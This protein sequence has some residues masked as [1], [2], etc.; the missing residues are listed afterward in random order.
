MRKRV[1][2]IRA[3]PGRRP[4]AHPDARRVAELFGLERDGPAGDA[5]M[6]DGLRLSLSAGEVVAVVGPSGA[7]KSVLLD[8]VARR[9]PDAARLDPA[10]LASCKLPAVAAV[11]AGELSLPERL[12]LL[13]RCGLAEARALV[14]P[15]RRLSGGQRHRL[16]YA[17]ALAAAGRTPRPLVIADEFAATLDPATAWA[18]ARQ[19]GKLARARRTAL[20]LATPRDE[21]LAAMRPDRLVVKPLG[22]P[23]RILERPDLPPVEPPGWRIERVRLRDYAPL[24]RFHYLAGPPAAH[25]RIWGVR[26]EARGPCAGPGAPEVAGV[27]VVSPPVRN[28]RGRNA[29]LPRRYTHRAPGLRR[30]NAEIECISRVIVHPLFRG[31]GLATALVRHALATAGTPMVEALA[32]MGE[33]HPLF[34]QAGMYSFGRFPGR[35]RRSAGYVYYLA[36]AR[37]YAEARSARPE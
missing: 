23:A 4:A 15:A 3:R 5:A 10:A 17:H 35:A 11:G 21:L 13:S 7:G 29:A 8:A 28:C 26:R 27:L 31:L 37:P 32:A 19:A 25:K 9:A 1:F 30:L 16:A 14:T 12:A 6:Y 33:V 20:L 2:T 36:R 22:A 18:F 34:E 24:S